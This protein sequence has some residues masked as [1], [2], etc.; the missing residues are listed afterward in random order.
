MW[1][2]FWMEYD[3]EEKVVVMGYKDEALN[4]CVEPDDIMVYLRDSELKQEIDD[5]LS[6]N[7]FLH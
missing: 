6:H 3:A 5:C 1:G 2:E 4:Y 7:L